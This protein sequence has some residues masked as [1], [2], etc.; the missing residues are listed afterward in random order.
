[1]LLNDY[2]QLEV[3]R[4]RAVPKAI[5][6]QS[7]AR[8]RHANP[9]GGLAGAIVDASTRHFET[10]LVDVLPLL[11]REDFV[12]VRDATNLIT[13]IVTTADVVRAYGQLA[14]PFFLIGQLDKA[15][16]ARSRTTSRS[17]R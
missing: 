4:P 8:E 7:I 1:M 11:E 13:G 15:C 3:H 6:W 14:T 10:D 2:S 5:T 16:V 17:T 9:Q 12:F